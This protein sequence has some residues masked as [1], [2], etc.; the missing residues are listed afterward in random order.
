MESM[1]QS[2]SVKMKKYKKQYEDKVEA[3]EEKIR[4]LEATTKESNQVG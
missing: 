4:Y 3:Y 2:L 1:V